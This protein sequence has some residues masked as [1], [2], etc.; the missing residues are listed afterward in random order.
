MCR[1]H[2]VLIIGPPLL[3]GEVQVFIEYVMLGPAVNCTEEHAHQ[4]GQLLSGRDVVVNLIPWNPILSPGM[5]F[6]APEGDSLQRFHR[7]VREQYG[8]PCTVRQ[9]K[10]QVCHSPS[11][12]LPCYLLALPRHLIC[13]PNCTPVTS[14]TPGTASA[15]THP[16][17]LCNRLT[18]H[19]AP[20]SPTQCCRPYPSRISPSMDVQSV[21]CPDLIIPA[22]YLWRMR[23]AGPGAWW[24]G[25]WKL[26]G[27]GAA[28]P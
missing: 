15:P 27:P 6:E 11:V 1:C 16:P 7:I 19:S 21:P 18:L 23:A 12:I 20:S 26:Q 4:L 13:T 22:G 24:E 17:D 28:S 2:I 10:G 5:E 9:E 3:F 25:G 14:C 8:L